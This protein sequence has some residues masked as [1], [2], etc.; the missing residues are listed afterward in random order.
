MAVTRTFGHLQHPSCYRLCCEMKLNL[1]IPQACRP[2]LRNSRC[3]LLG[4]EV[5]LFCIL[6][7]VL[8]IMTRVSPDVQFSLYLSPQTSEQ[9]GRRG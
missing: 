5:L 9:G 4:C 3:F 8:G 6:L 1:A 7:E 2:E